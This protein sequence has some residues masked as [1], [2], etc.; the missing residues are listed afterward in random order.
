MNDNFYNKAFS[1]DEKK[2]IN[3][4]NLLDVGTNDD[5]FLLSYEEAEKYFA[6]DTAR[7]CKATDYAVKNGVWVASS[8]GCGIWWLRSPYPDDSIDVFNVSY[9]GFNGDCYYVN[10][11]N[12]LARPALSI[13]L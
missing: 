9:D 8:N 1:E 4:S 5:V 3:Y 7:Q 13:N 11:V 12:F 10:Y 6:N 2:V